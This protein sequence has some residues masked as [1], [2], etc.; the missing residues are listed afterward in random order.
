M[1]DVRWNDPKTTQ[2]VN[3]HV[4]RV[5]GPGKVAGTAKY[6]FDIVLPGMLYGKILRCPHALA[7]VQAIDTSAAKAMPGVRAVIEMAREGATMRYAGQEVAAVA[8]DSEE[9]ALDAIRAIR[10]SYDVQS[11]AVT[12]HT[13]MKDASRV[14]APEEQARGQDPGQFWSSAAAVIEEEYYCPV[15]G[16]LCLESHGIVFRW[17]AD[18][19]ATCWVSTQAVHGVAGELS[20]GLGI[21]QENLTVICEYMGGG[22]GSKF[23]AGVEGATCARLAKAAGK[24]VKLM[25]DRY[26]DQVAGGNAP[27]AYMKCKAAMAADGKL[28]AI[29]ADLYGTNGPGRGWG[30]PFPY[31]Y[32]VPNF[33]VRTHSVSTNAG[34]ARAWRAPGHPQASFLMESVVDELICKLGLDGVKVRQMNQGSQVRSAQLELGAAKIGWERRN[35]NPGQA[36]GRYQRG[37]GCA[38][39]TWGGGGRGG[40]RCD[41]KI[42]QDGSVWA[43]IGTQDLGT[44]ARTVVAMIVAEDLGLPLERVKADIGKSSLGSSVGSG[45]SVT[46]ASIAPT[47]KMAVLAARARLFETAAPLL[48]VTA[49]ELECAKGRVQARGNPSKS[50]RFEEVCAKLP[51]GGISE[52]G[53]WNGALQQGGVAG[54]QFVEVEVDTWTGNVRPIKVVAAQDCG[55]AINRL[56]A[57]SQVIGG[58]IQGLGMA[59]L[60]DRRMDVPT[61]RQLNANIES[62]RVIGAMEVPDVEVVLFDTHDK[63][64]GIGEPPVIPTAAA[65]INAIYNATG[66]RIRTLPATPKRWFDALGAKS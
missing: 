39:S 63:V 19:R 45:G 47:I 25:L 35:K 4:P 16:H 49:G 50:L 6:T 31:I 66:V 7:T 62:Y 41:V 32:G 38:V 36:T 30:V 10:V 48:G 13:A 5:D 42:G 58:V 34:A 44:G 55:Y 8:A 40:S 56:T 33:R 24:P 1:Q 64:A 37:I 11:H 2:Y 43:G 60:E 27:D 54:A 29:E 57:E 3:K 9:I 53:S 61:G 20:G 17:D 65:T 14:S 28:L 46:T 23:G 51:A 12:T 15:R 22:F 21:P 59:L 52:S 26:E 18:D